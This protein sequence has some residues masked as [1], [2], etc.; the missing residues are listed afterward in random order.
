MKNIILL[1]VL[2][3]S[4]SSCKSEDEVLNENIKTENP[5]DFT[6]L[7]SVV[8]TPFLIPDITKYLYT[9][10]TLKNVVTM[11]PSKTV[12]NVKVVFNKNGTVDVYEDGKKAYQTTFTLKEESGNS[13]K[14][15]TISSEANNLADHPT[16]KHIIA[17]T[18]RLC[19]KELILDHGMAF[20]AP[21]YMFRKTE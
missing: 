20:D 6:C 1:F 18:I 16:I 7:N 2:L 13:Y 4:F 14:W 9:S 21:A 11:V 5:A 12:P 8:D 10:W 17:G 19:E 15:V 3:A